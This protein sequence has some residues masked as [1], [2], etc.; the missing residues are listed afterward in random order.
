MKPLS[1]A[2]DFHTSLLGRLCHFSCPHR[3]RRSS[4][5][6]VGTDQ[7]K[8]DFDVDTER[9]AKLCSYGMYKLEARYTPERYGE[10]VEARADGRGDRSGLQQAAPIGISMPG[11]R[12]CGQARA[13]PEEDL[14]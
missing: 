10:A 11:P 7:G 2:A 12:F 6:Q 8:M 3:E 4:Q 14:S 9:S 5:S 1:P 13:G